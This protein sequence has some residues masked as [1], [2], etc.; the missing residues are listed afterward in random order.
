[1]KGEDKPEELP[2]EVLH[3][4]QVEFSPEE[5]EAVRGRAFVTGKSPSE[6]VQEALRWWLGMG[7]GKRE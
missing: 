4:K 6:V 3:L 1:M 2:G 5:W 7:E